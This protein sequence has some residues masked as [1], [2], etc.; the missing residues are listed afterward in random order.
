MIYTVTPNPTWDKTL[1]TPKL[2]PGEFHRT[3]FIR[4][5]I[6]GKG[7]NV[8][9]VLKILGIE[10][11]ALG[12]IGGRI[13]EAFRVGLAEEGLQTDFIDVADETRTNITL[14]DESNGVYTK[15]NEPGP[16]ISAEHI[17]ALYAQVEQYT[18]P[19]DIWVLSGSL[20]PGA[21]VD[22]YAEIIRRVQERGGRAFLDT[23]EVP[24]KAGLEARPFGVK[25]NSD[26][27]ADLFG[28]PLKTDA[29]HA[30]AVRCLLEM[31]AQ[32][33]AITR[34]ADGLMLSA[35]G[36]KRVVMAVPPQVEVRSAVS[37]GD[38]SLTGMLWGLIEGCDAVEMARRAVAC[39]TAAAMQD[40][41]AVGDRALIE[42]LIGRV[43]IR[44][45]PLPEV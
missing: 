16:T 43:E 13:G 24:L 20:P 7:I 27:A 14:L 21:P 10:S 17:A 4:Q 29:D 39:G 32:I 3:K 8:S 23:S 6:S 44:I 28:Q 36:D 22:L 26:E 1:S 40:G 18:L 37:A 45:E 38:A 9:R 30:A 5:D 15:I 25:P 34:G 19:N 41:S 33:A 35:A 12:F 11:K 42:S 2:R 31:G